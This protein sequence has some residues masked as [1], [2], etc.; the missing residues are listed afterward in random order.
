MMDALRLPTRASV[1]R[2]LI[3]S[4]IGVVAAV[5]MIACGGEADPGSP[6]PSAASAPPIPAS[7]TLGAA[8]Q[9]ATAKAVAAYNAYFAEYVAAAAIPDPDDPRPSDYLGGAL[10]SLS[11][12]NI[13][14]LQD[15]GAVELGHPK[16]TVTATHLDLAGEPPTV[17]IDACVDYSDFRL[18][19]KDSQSPVPNSS[20]DRVRYTTTATVNLF[21][22]DRW[23][24]SDDSPHRDTPC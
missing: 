7:P 9:A 13:R 15:H 19:Y 17:T 2:G 16:T 22:D 4:T 23:L 14:M 1:R 24:V 8:E 6:T 21:A 20:L 12:H 10:L 18:V 5:S 3:I 11:R